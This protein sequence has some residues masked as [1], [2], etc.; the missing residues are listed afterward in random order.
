MRLKIKNAKSAK[1]VPSTKPYC[2]DIVIDGIQ[3]HEL[4]MSVDIM[5]AID[6]YGVTEL[7]D[8]IEERQLNSHLQYLGEGDGQLQTR[9]LD[10]P[11]TKRIESARCFRP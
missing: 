5:A 6:Y 2:L 7:L 1:I 10:P 3:V 9:E 4:L 11:S 8:V